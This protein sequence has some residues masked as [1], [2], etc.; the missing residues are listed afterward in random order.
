[1]TLIRKSDDPLHPRF[2][3]VNCIYISIQFFFNGMGINFFHKVAS[4]DENLQYG[5]TFVKFTLDKNARTL[6][7]PFL[8]NMSCVYVQKIQTIT[9]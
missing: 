7:P 5:Y 2:E 1:M 8:K 4:Q 9:S 6:S 3:E